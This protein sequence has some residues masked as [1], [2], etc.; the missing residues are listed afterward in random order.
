[1]KKYDLILLVSI[2]IS[3]S[4]S[5]GQ[6][7]EIADPANYLND[8]KVE[9]NKEWPKNRTVN[10]VFHGHSVPAGYYKAPLVKPFGAYP[11]MLLEE[12]KEIYPYAVINIINTS[13]GGENAVSGA[14]RFDSDV[15]VHKPDVLFIDYSLN[16]R[17]AGL[18][19]SKEAWV[20]MIGKALND[21]IKIILF[22]PSPDTRM[23][24]LEPN[25]ILEQHSKQVRNLA[26][27][28]E[29]GLI[30]SYDLFRNKLL[31]GDSLSIYMSS[32]V[33]P[34]EKGHQI[35]TD[36]LIKYFK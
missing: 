33:D 21:S 30:D 18:E 8:I 9:L 19:A 29:I 5:S 34:N 2:V 4:F 15:L 36:E 27:H 10:L 28:Y 11:L 1:M 14:D 32:V 26:S 6:D 16:D 13:I 23:D 25:N 20:S 17:G 35:I 12:L 22:T 3:F 31:A 24:I 7:S